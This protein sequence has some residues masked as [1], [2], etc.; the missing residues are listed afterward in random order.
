MRRFWIVLILVLFMVA[1]G[2][3]TATEPV[4][5]SGNT[6]TEN[7][8][9]NDGGETETTGDEG[10]EAAQD[11]QTEPAEDE[12]AAGAE[13][14]EEETANE[15]DAAD[16]STSDEGAT[17]EEAADEAMEEEDA[18]AGEE[19]AMEDEAGV[20]LQ[21]S[22]TD[23]ETGLEINPDPIPKG[24]EFIAIGEVIQMNLTPQ[25]SPEFVIRAPN[26]L[27]YRIATQALGDIVTVDGTALLPHEYKINMIAQA[28]A[29]LAPDAALSDVLT[30]D[31]FTIV[32]LP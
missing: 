29:F 7:A 1:C 24:V 32:V 16:E 23:P 27:T 5:N 2:G 19:A 25:S 11:A 18:A 12:S 22:G 6:N 28:T 15:E 26:N 13:D 3:N 10:E 4:A 17:E 31:D 21:M 30:A 8:A 20:D 14:M 9:V